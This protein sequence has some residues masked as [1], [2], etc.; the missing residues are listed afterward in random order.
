MK[1]LKSIQVISVPPCLGYAYRIVILLE[2]ENGD[3]LEGPRIVVDDKECLAACQSAVL[4][5]LADELQLHAEDL[6]AG[7]KN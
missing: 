4:R 1:T 6:D 5:S 3:L 7:G 2:D